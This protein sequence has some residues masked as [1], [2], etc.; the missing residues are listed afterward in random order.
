MPSES[1]PGC[2]AQPARSPDPLSRSF[3]SHKL[4]GQAAM[5]RSDRFRFPGSH[6]RCAWPG[7][8]REPGKWQRSGR[9]TPRSAVRGNPG[10]IRSAHSGTA[11]P[12]SKGRTTQSVTIAEGDGRIREDRP[13]LGCHGPAMARSPDAQSLLHPLVKVTN[14]HR[15]RCNHHLTVGMRASSVDH[16]PAEDDHFHISDVISITLYLLPEF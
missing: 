9:R 10:D 8:R 11:A 15:R 12:T 16:V 5:D 2:G 4:F 13:G 1:A 14:T 7:S 3:A 6:S